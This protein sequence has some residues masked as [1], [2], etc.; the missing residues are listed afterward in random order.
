MTGYFVFKVLLEDTGDIVRLES[1]PY[2]SQSYWYDYTNEK[3]RERVVVN[4][5]IINNERNDLYTVFKISEIGVGNTRK[6][7]FA[8]G[9]YMTFKRRSSTDYTFYFYA[10]NG[11][12][13]NEISNANTNFTYTGKERKYLVLGGPISK[14]PYTTPSYEKPAIY[15]DDMPDA[16][17]GTYIN[18]DGILTGT[19]TYESYITST[20]GYGNPIDYGHALIGNLINNAPYYDPSFWGETSKEQGGKGSFGYTTDEISIPNLPGVSALSTG[21]LTMYK[22]SLSSINTLAGYLW[23]D[24]FLTNLKKYFVSPSEAIISLSLAPFEITNINPN[25][26]RVFVGNASTPASGNQIVNQYVQLDF[27]I[28]DF[29]EYWGNYIDYELTEVS[30][31]L[32]Y[33]GN[34]KL[35]AKDVVKSKLHLIYNVDLLSGECVALIN[36]EK[37]YGLKSVIY[38]YNGNILSR[39]PYSASDMSAY[40]NTVLSTVST[41]ISGGLLG[42]GGA[43]ASVAVSSAFGAKKESVIKGGSASGG[44]GFLSPQRPYLII[45]RPDQS[46][47][48]KFNTFVGY[49]S[50]ITKKLSACSGYTEVDTI[51]LENIPATE[52]EISEIESLLK[53]GVIIK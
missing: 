2:D 23:N 24:A 8:D 14:I 41:G 40:V 52:S 17:I 20:K 13:Y 18:T 29:K 50:N 27:G 49:P 26:S 36:L 16:G 45:T 11:S 53:S 42:T 25:A 35:D 1:V 7:L 28:V 38:Q 21:F 43:I 37:E 19:S 30:V 5:D 51:H 46:L 34:Y 44:K 33:C 22:M 10:P 32:P 4:Y 31:Y 47:P 9:S 12:L 48:D 6:C 15:S 3:Y 39:I